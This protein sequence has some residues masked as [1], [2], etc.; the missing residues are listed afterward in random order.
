[1]VFLSLYNPIIL[2]SHPPPG[3]AVQVREIDRDRYGR[4]VAELFVA[5]KAINL[6]MIKEG[7]AVVYPIFRRFTSRKGIFISSL[8]QVVTTT[9]ISKKLQNLASLRRKITNLFVSC[10]YYQMDGLKT[11]KHPSHRGCICQLA[12]L[13][14]DTCFSCT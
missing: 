12:L 7:Q 6:Q 2:R 9:G 4:T 14:G 3:T 13:I 1:M 5:N 10:N 8:H 11:L